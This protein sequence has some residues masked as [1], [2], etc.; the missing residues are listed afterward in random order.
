MNREFN[1]II[2]L[3]K[4]TLNEVLGKFDLNFFKKLSWTEKHD[5]AEKHLPRLGTGSSRDVYALSGHKVLKISLDHEKGFGQNEAEVEIY[6]NP[7]T[8]PIISKIYDF[9]SKNYE[10]LISEIA[11][12]FQTSKE[13]EEK[14]GISIFDLQTMNRFKTIDKFLKFEIDAQNAKYIDIK[15]YLRMFGIVVDS[16]P[17]ALKILDKLIQDIMADKRI[18]ADINYYKLKQFL[19]RMIFYQKTITKIQSIQNISTVNNLLLGIQTLESLGLIPS[20]IYRY[21][22][23]GITNDNRV[24]LIDYGATREVMEKYYY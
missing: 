11:K 5:Y 3:I 2:F 1:N 22:H 7:M 10:W 24:V 13:F 18:D 14:V 20:D 16:I 19:E 9:D 6:S 12:P 17:E 8:K 21:E 4:E 15:I 23:F